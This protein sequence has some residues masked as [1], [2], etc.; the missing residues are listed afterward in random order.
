MGTRS[1]LLIL[2]AVLTLL[3]TACG[4]DGESTDTTGGDTET[5]SADTEAETTEA[6]ETTMAES[7]ETE[8]TETTTAEAATEPAAELECDVVQVIVPYSPGGG[9]DQ[10][11]RRLQTALEDALGVRLQITYQEGG[12]GSVGW[13]ALAQAAPD[14][15]TISNVVAPNIMNL[16]L[17]ASEDIGFTAEDFEYLGWTE[18]SPN[19]IQPLYQRHL[20]EVVGVERVMIGTDYPFD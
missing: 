4:D 19:I 15:C 2:M 3:V 17:T 10:Q 11:V 9:S 6:T 20:I 7:E 13:N 12:D 14:G 16:S 18:Y 5:T 8:P 1:K